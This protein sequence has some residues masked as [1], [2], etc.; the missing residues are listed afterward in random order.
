MSS[1]GVEK[2]PE[3]AETPKD[4]TSTVSE[5]VQPKEV[6]LLDPKKVRNGRVEL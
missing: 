6:D 1:T 4:T 3:V 5:P 2:L